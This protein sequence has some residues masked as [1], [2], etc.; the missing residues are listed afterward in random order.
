MLVVEK[1]QNINID[2]E[3]GVRHWVDFNEI[4][5]EGYGSLSFQQ[6]WNDLKVINECFEDSEED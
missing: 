5:R 2:K 6:I 4:D 1:L 3:M